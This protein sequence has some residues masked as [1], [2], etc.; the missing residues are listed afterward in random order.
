[1]KDFISKLN[2]VVILGIVLARFFMAFIFKWWLSKR[3]VEKPRNLKRNVISPAVMPEGAN[4]DMDNRTGAAPWTNN[5]QMKRQQTMR[6]QRAKTAKPNARKA[7]NRSEKGEGK[8]ANEFI[9]ADGMISAAANL[10]P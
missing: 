2:W 10:L 9:G 6:L 7:E 1:M 5:S 8:P 3:L 4:V